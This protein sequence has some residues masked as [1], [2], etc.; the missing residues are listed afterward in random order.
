M[1]RGFLAFTVRSKAYG[2]DMTSPKEMKKIAEWIKV[3]HDNL[4]ND[5]KIQEVANEV[6]AMTKEFP[7]YKMWS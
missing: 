4:D 7:L 2:F 3:A 6:I 5:S 1:A